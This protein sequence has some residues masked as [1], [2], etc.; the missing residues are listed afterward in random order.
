MR[1]RTQPQ[2]GLQQEALSVLAAALHV[3]WDKSI[4]CLGLRL[5][6]CKLGSLGGKTRLFRETAQHRP[7]TQGTFQKPWALLFLPSDPTIEAARLA[8]KK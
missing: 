6:V 2:L 3:T 4:H 1:G 8:P 5:Q 7:V